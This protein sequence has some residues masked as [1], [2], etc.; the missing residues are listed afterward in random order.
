[1]NFD[2][3][4]T[5]TIG[6]VAVSANK[7][8]AVLNPATEEIIAQVPSAGREELDAAVVAARAAFPGWSN[9]PPAE[10]Q[11]LVAA[12]G[13]RLEQH[14]EELMRLLTREQGK[15]RSGAEWELTGAIIWCREIAKQELPVHIAEDSAERTVETRH[16]PIGV[17]GA[18][19]PWN[20]PI[21][22]AIW[23]VLP[24]L[25]A[26]NTIIVKPSPYT[27][28]ATLKIGEMM[29]DVL[30]PGVLN[31]VSGGNELGQLMTNHPDIG[32]ISFTGSTQTGK[33]IME[34]AAGTL[35]RITLELGGNDAAIVLPDVD[36]KVVAKEIFWAAFQNSAQ[37]CVAAK[38]LFVHADIYD[39]L[40]HELVEYAK[41]VKLGDGSEQ[42]VD[43]GPI[44]NKMQFEKVKDLLADAR[45]KGLKFL[46]GGDVPEGKGYFVPVAIVDNPP[47]DARVVVEEAFGPVL[48]LLKFSDLDDVV[49][50]ANDTIYGLGGSVWSA[51]PSAARKIAERL[52]CGTIWINEIHAFS[53][54]ATFS[55]HK[56][57]GIGV[58]NAIQGLL[59]FTNA[60]TI[61]TKKIATVA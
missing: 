1:M 3:D 19:T 13:E 24:A 12:I 47:D 39:A 21:L 5:M 18:I 4:Y 35:K 16:V 22:L 6:G 46:L 10:R 23:K 17:V 51:D 43:L 32:K 33:R 40:S 38:R 9:R 11:A 30:P 60:Q 41:T 57:S 45:D 15:P 53:P 48:P 27:P 50:R 54:H 61:V 58:E 25:L 29:R 8:A 55:G 52:E 44:Q 31:V 26:G 49:V 28:L 37:L 7:T 2:S 42:G 34:S 20:Y 56:Q 14:K 36:P 59:E